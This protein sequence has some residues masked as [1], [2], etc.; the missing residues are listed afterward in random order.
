MTLNQLHILQ[1]S[2]GRDQY[3]HGT[4]YRNHYCAG[5]AC[6]EAA[7]RKDLAATYERGYLAGLQSYLRGSGKITCAS[8]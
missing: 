4:D 2:L 6:H 8:E 3:G 1:H 7:H 5:C